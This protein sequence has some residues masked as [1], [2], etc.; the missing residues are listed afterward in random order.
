MVFGVYLYDS[1]SARQRLKEIEEKKYFSDNK[2]L[3]FNG[4]TVSRN[5]NNFLYK[6]LEVNT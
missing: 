1:V 5:A 3:T 2:E 6:V 4:I